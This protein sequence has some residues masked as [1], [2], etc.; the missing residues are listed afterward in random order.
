MKLP[1]EDKGYSDPSCHSRIK[2][3]DSENRGPLNNHKSA[4]SNET[5]LRGSLWVLCAQIKRV[6]EEA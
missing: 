3:D 6:K 1:L 2:K 5:L 4:V